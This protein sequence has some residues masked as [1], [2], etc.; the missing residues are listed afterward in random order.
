MERLNLYTLKRRKVKL[1]TVVIFSLL[2]LIPGIVARV[3]LDLDWKGR[4]KEIS[5]SY[6]SVMKIA[7]YSLTGNERDIKVLNSAVKNY[8]LK[9]DI[10]RAKQKKTIEFI[11]RAY[12]DKKLLK[13][14]LSSWAKDK[15]DWMVLRELNWDSKSLSLD[16]YEI[17]K[18]GIESRG[19]DLVSR[20]RAFGFVKEKVE[21]DVDFI[22]DLKLK[23]VVISADVGKAYK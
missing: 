16:F 5:L 18:P 3:I 6:S 17:Y 9:A 15:E 2:M 10:M 23:K 7:E 20:L 19:C 12:V 13:L 1:I 11:K 8:Q 14:V 22:D 4:V 21:F